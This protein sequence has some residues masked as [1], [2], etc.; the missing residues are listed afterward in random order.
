M[1]L[2]TPFKARCSGGTLDNA[3]ESTGKSNVKRGQETFC[4]LKPKIT[5]LTQSMWELCLNI[6]G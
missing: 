6:Q 2:K 1:I 4:S 5:P 3:L